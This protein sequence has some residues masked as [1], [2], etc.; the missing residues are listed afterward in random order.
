MLVSAL[1]EH[2]VIT[3]K[4]VFVLLDGGSAL[5]YGFRTHQSALT[6][7]HSRLH[8]LQMSAGYRKMEYVNI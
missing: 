4:Y 8:Q 1:L 2:L 3:I 7:A 5:T 6:K